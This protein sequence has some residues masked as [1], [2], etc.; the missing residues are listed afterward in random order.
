MTRNV[1]SANQSFDGPGN[2]NL[3]LESQPLPLQADADGILRVAG[4]R[5]TLDTV[6]TAFN[7]GA[8]A[9]QIAHDYPVLELPDIYAVITFYLQRRRE[10][11]EYLSEQRTAG[12]QIRAEM[13]ARFDPQGIRDRLLARRGKKDQR[14]ASAAGG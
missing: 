9:E 10:V 12:R 7:S 2:V 11:D 1:F 4:T 8:T 5:V 14:D 3:T 6:V 13:E